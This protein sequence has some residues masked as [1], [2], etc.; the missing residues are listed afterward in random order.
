MK[1]GIQGVLHYAS[2]TVLAKTPVFVIGKE[3]GEPNKCVAAL[4]PE[5]KLDVLGLGSLRVLLSDPC[6]VVVKSY[7]RCEQGVKYI[8]HQDPGVFIFGDTGFMFLAKV[9]AAFIREVV[10]ENAEAF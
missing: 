10:T 7:D 8:S 2:R 6:C 3:R 5:S 9:I 4:V 1:L